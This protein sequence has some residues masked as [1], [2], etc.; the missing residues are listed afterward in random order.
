M[1]GRDCRLY[2]VD[3]RLGFWD[4]GKGEGKLAVLS[5]KCEGK[6]YL[7]RMPY[8]RMSKGSGF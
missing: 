2:S 3:C 4:V 6:E 7:R 5:A 8:G 1:E